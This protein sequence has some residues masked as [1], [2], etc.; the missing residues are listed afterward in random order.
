MDDGCLR[1]FILEDK[2]QM[3]ATFSELGLHFLYPENWLLQSEEADA[4]TT[5]VIFE[6]PS[7]GFFSVETI[8]EEPDYDSV[9][10]QIEQAFVDEYGETEAEEFPTDPEQMAGVHLAFDFRF[11]YLDL[12]IISR[13]MFLRAGNQNYILQFQAEIRDFESNEMVIAA[14]LKQIAS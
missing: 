6:L 10:Q 4:A 2:F 9:I 8:E 11:Y 13:L 12:L 14:I 3:P 5:G 1:F 7:G